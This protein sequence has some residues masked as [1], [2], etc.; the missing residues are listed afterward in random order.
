[1]NKKTTVIWKQ[2]G[3]AFDAISKNGFSFPLGVTSGDTITPSELL[4][5]S[6]IGCTAFDVI[7]ILEKKKASVSSFFV[8]AETT[9]SQEIPKRIEAIHLQYTVV[10]NAVKE[11]DVKRAIQLSEEKYCMIRNTLKDVVSI[12]SD[13]KIQSV[14]E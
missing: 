6:L 13:Y 14:N 10:G 5:L 1:M 7:S 3:L 11:E 8:E 9:V 12:T 4:V 2:S